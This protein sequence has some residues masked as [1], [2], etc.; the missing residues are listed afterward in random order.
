MRVV[1]KLLRKRYDIIQWHRYQ[2]FGHTAKYCR[3][4]HICM[5]CAGEHLA[6]DC[7]RPRIE[8]STCYNCGQHPAND[9]GCTKL[10]A[11][12]QWS[13]PRSGV[14]RRTE[15]N[16]RQLRRAYL[17][18]EISYADVA[19]LTDRHKQPLSLVHQQNN[20]QLQSKGRSLSRQRSRLKSF[21]GTLQLDGN[22]ISLRSIQEK[23]M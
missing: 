21:A 2:Q 23:Q 6:E 19:K 17:E 8:L 9:K 4:I 7:T 1:I 10:Q 15:V 14:S 20:Q 5:K 13:R 18:V 11:F 12:L 16:E 3:K 22:I